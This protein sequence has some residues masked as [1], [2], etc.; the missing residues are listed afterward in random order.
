MS[1]LIARTGIVPN[2]WISVGPDDPVPES[3]CVLLPLSR[4]TAE[5]RRLVGRGRRVGVVLEPGDEPGAIAED[6][7]SLAL[8]AIRFPHFTDGRG[9]STARLLRERWRYRGELR[10]TGDVARDQLFY[11]SRVGF[12]T[13]A[14]RDG[15]DP[16]VALAAFDDFSEAY[17]ASIDRPQPLFRR[18]PGPLEPGVAGSKDD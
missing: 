8:I 2:R 12:D 9:Y 14:L 16:E 3:G 17:Q 7:P 6:L 1:A 15:E 13:F 10:A 5:R 11:L 4:W 18:R